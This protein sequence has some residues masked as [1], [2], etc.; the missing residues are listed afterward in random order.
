MSHCL[1]GV[2][3]ASHSWEGSVGNTGL[4]HSWETQDFRE[5]LDL[6]DFWGECSDDEVVKPISSPGENLVS[7]TLSH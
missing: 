3:M 1:L 7:I 2:T 6:E 5:D 4:V